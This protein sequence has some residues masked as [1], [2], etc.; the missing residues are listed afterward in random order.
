MANANTES[1]NL[2]D[3]RCS[4]AFLYFLQG[5]DFFKS[6]RERY[7]EVYKTHILGSPTIRVM[8]AEN[9]RKVLMGEHNLVAT[10]WPSS[11]RQIMG[12]GALF[13]SYGDAHRLRRRVTQK[14]NDD[15][16]DYDYD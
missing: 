10:W 9:V 5:V 15:D 13:N 6:R 14:G 1:A 8:G 3:S 11:V 4:K 7:G 2:P 16:D 12:G